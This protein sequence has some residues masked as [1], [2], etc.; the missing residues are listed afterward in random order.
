MKIEL[1]GV[2]KAF[3]SKWALR[4]IHQEF[5]PGRIVAVLGLNGAGKSTL[6]QCLAG[7]LSL[8]EGRVHYD[9]KVFGR[10]CVDLRRRFAFLPDFPLFFPTMN[11]LQHIGMVMRLYEKDTPGAEERVVELLRGFDLLPVAEAALPS[12][13]RGQLY[14]VA[15][16]ATIAASPDLWLLDEPMA[17]GMDALGLREFR[18]RAR[19]AANAGTT[20]FYTTQILS[21]AEQFSD[22][23]LVLHQGR[24]HARGAADA[25]HS[26]G[27]LEELLASL[28]EEQ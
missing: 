6:L 11:A 23:V 19:A 14:K 8:S 5:A 4:Q 13:S 21:V 7:I 10:E 20:I 16:V 3:G 2:S 15:L 26:S 1:E 27:E 22:E 24:V 12:L 25:L 17:S 18:S 9:G 28:H